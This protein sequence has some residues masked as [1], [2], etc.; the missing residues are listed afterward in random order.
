L[1]VQLARDPVALVLLRGRQAPLEVAPLRLRPL[2]ARDRGRERPV[3]V[4]QFGRPLPHPL[5]QPRVR[6]L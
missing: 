1:V 4:L 3:R 2:A 6:R 5:L